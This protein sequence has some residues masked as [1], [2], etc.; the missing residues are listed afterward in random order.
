MDQSLNILAVESEPLLRS[1]YD[2]L[3][4]D[5]GHR[6]TAVGSAE[7]AIRSMEKAPDQYDV[8]ITDLALP[9]MDGFVFRDV[10][11]AREPDLP[12]VIISARANQPEYRKKVLDSFEGS[13][14]KPFQI[15]ELQSLLEK[16]MN[17]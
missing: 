16:L 14:S 9:G 3:F 6:V 12:V 10:L 13:L 11:K 5:L 4:Q 15:E 7:A 1:Y 17:Q 2:N 8:I